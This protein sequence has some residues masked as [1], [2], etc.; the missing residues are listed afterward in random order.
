MLVNLAKEF[1]MKWKD[2]EYIKEKHVIFCIIK[3]SLAYHHCVKLTLK[4]LMDA[5]ETLFETCKNGKRM[6]R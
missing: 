4:E 5:I 6:E 2:D 1:K 3:E